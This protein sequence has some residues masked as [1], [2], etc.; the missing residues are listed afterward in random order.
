[1]ANAVVRYDGPA[2][3]ERAG[4]TRAV[5][6][7]S[8]RDPAA[9]DLWRRWVVANALGEALGLGLAAGMGVALL[10]PGAPTLPPLLTA[11]AMVAVGCLEGY[12]V[13]TAQSLALR[14]ALPGLTRRAWVAATVAGAALAWA[15][16]MLPSTL[17]TGDGG[18]GPGALAET[19]D[20]VMYGL[21]AAMGVVLGPLLGWAQW[22]VLRRHARGAGRWVWANAAAWAVGM[23]IVFAGAGQAPPAGP[24]AVPFV[25]AVLAAAGGAVGAV[26]GAVLV[27][28]VR[29]RRAG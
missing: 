29:D 10:G 25:L 13:G 2:S 6:G 11:G 12:V 19:S 4:P 15:L 17:A 28:L 9:G 24:L 3:A 18:G 22:L 5:R 16:G 23:P 21:A 27:R 26:H 20:L 8:D 14:P 7:R 1:M